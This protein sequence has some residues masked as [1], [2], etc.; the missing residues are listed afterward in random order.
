MVTPRVDVID[1]KTRTEEEPVYHLS[2]QGGNNSHKA[3][4]LDYILA[5]FR[6]ATYPA[7]QFGISFGYSIMHLESVRGE[8]PSL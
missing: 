8:A 1:I 6:I 5:M 3:Q 4:M 2:I 7:T